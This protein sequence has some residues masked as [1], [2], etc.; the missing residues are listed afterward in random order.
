M[1]SGIPFPPDLPGF[2]IRG[3]PRFLDVTIPNYRP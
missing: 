2:T 1:I 3:P